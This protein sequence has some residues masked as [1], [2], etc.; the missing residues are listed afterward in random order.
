VLVVLLVVVA[1][2]GVVASF[3]DAPPEAEEEIEATAVLVPVPI[4][5]PDRVG[6]GR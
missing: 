4:L 6:A 2:E 5:F 1:D 3:A